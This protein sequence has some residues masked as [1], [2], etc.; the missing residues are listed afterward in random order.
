[1]AK[2]Y[3]NKTAQANGDHE[4]HETGC[5]WLSRATNTRYLGYFPSC[6]GAVVSAKVV[7]PTAN[8]CATCSRACHTG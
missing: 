2:Y 1:M 7:Y 5:Y 8:G 3:V 6:Y 4:V